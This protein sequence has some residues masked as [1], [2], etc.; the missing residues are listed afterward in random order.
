VGG[1]LV[2][3]DARRLARPAAVANDRHQLRSDVVAVVVGR[4]PADCSC[5]VRRPQRSVPLALVD[6]VQLVS[7]PDRQTTAADWVVDL[8]TQHI[9]T[10][11]LYS[12]VLA[13]IVITSGQ[14]NLT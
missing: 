10:A 14:I 5:H 7:V 12:A 8:P 6:G 1:L 13:V 11:Q 2:E 3:Q 9:S 4:L